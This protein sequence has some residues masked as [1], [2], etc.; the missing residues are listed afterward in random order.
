MRAGL[1]RLVRP[2]ACLARRGKRFRG[3][4]RGEGFGGRLRYEDVDRWNP[5][6]VRDHEYDQPLCEL[7][8]NCALTIHFVVCPCSRRAPN[9]EYVD[10]LVAIDQ[11][12]NKLST[13]EAAI[14]RQAAAF[15]FVDHVFFR[16]FDD[17]RSSKV[18]AYI[19]DNLHFRERTPFGA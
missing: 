17:H 4:A 6:R 14:V 9:G 11:S 2:D 15:E 8:G 5:I 13:D 18:C 19:V 10:G 12:L 1:A 3:R 16:R 7:C